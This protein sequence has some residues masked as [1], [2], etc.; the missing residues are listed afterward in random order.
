MRQETTRSANVTPGTVTIT[1]TATGYLAR[2]YSI[3]VTA[4]ATSTQNVQLSTSGKIA[5]N[6]TGNGAALWGQP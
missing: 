6:V 2:S 3:A 4:G 5:G 1:G